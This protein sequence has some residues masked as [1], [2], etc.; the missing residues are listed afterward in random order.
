[1]YTALHGK[2]LHRKHV[3]ES[4]TQDWDSGLGATQCHGLG[5]VALTQNNQPTNKH[6][7]TNQNQTTK[8]KPHETKARKAK[9]TIQP[10]NKK[11]IPFPTKTNNQQ[12]MN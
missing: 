2:A 7:T 10:K 9:T 5:S 3:A 8:T 4:Q 12:T 11:D 1:L 6:K